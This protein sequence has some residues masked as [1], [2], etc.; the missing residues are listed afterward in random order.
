MKKVFHY[1]CSFTENIKSFGLEHHFT[2]SYVYCNYGKISSGN[3]YILNKF[4]DT[5]EYDCT[6]II[7]WSSLTRPFDENFEILQTSTNPLYD[8]LEEW[9]TI[10]QEANQ[11]AKQNNIKLI[12]YIGWAQW[13]DDE[14][15]NYH[16]EKLN[17]FD[18]TWFESKKQWDII[19]ANCFQFQIPSKWSSSPKETPEGTYS[20][21]SDIHWGGMSEW[22]RSNIDMHNRYVGMCRDEIGKRSYYDSHP[23]GYATG[24][25]I[26]QVLLPK[27]Q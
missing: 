21:W 10:L 25:F 5:V 19:P 15:N 27:I 24:E 18:I 4:K 11:F 17:S 20:F 2:D 14:L 8:Y 13:K 12:Q 3:R 22:I 16:R 9:Y 7:Q 6:A 23:S 1:G 26:K